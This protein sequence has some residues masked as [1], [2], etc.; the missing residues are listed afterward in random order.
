MRAKERGFGGT[1]IKIGK[2]HIFDDVRRL[3]AVRDQ[4]GPAW[5]I[6]TD[7]NQGFSLNEAIRR[8]RAYEE[9]DVA[10]V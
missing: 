4:V 10:W 8:A 9:L 7:A 6:M 5:E 2:P 1:K 3:S